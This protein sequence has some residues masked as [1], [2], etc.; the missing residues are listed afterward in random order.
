VEHRDTPGLSPP[1]YNNTL[2]RVPPVGEWTDE[3]MVFLAQRDA[4]F[5]GRWH[6]CAM[7]VF[8]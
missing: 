7:P 8:L 4:G 2:K 1:L 3:R 6:R 5:G